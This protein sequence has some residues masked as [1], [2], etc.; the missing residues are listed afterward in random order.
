MASAKAT[1]VAVV[2]LVAVLIVGAILA[3]SVVH[4]PVTATSLYISV[5]RESDFSG[6]FINDHGGCRRTAITDRWICDVTPRNGTGVPSSY[7][8]TARHGSSCWQARLI[9][10]G[11]TR[12]RAHGCVHLWEAK[13]FI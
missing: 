11:G 3:R 13:G 6:E 12:P 4:G 2:G 7:V 1:G 5:N 8:V 9:A 10:G